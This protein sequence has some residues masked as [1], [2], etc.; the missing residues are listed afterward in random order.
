MFQR[1]TIV[2]SGIRILEL[3]GIRF[4][5]LTLYLIHSEDLDH[6]ESLPMF[7]LQQAFTFNFTIIF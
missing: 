1:P 2:S 5:Y 7:Q 6:L 3:K 4:D